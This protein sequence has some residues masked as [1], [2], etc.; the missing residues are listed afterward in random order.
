MIRLALLRHGHTDWNRQGRIQG[1][2]DIPLDDEARTCL[3]ALRLPNDWAAAELWSSPLKRAA[4][5]AELVARRAP[6]LAPELVEMNW[7]DWEGQR[8]LDLLATPGSGFRHIEE[9][10]WD[11][12]APGG[13]TPRNLWTRLKP[14]L[15]RLDRSALAVCHIGVMRVLLARAH[16]WDFSGP[17]PFRIK[18]NRLYVLRLEGETLTPEGEPIRLIPAEGAA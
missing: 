16:G 5:T 13:E 10:G 9:W 2:S 14:W 18:R 11:Y 17:A 3:A 4:E 12:H 8:G 1:A 6:R 15:A 7:G